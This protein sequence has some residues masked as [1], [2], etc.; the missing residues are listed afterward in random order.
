MMALAITGNVHFFKLKKIG[1][2]RIVYP[3]HEMGEA[4]RDAKIPSAEVYSGFCIL[5]ELFSFEKISRIKIRITLITTPINISL[6][7]VVKPKM[8]LFPGIMIVSG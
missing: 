4:K 1:S 7:L 3:V 6:N 2:R 8:E 5:L